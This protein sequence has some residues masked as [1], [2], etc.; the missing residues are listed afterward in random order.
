[1]ALFRIVDVALA[2]LL[3]KSTWFMK[4]TEE[5]KELAR[6]IKPN[7]PFIKCVYVQNRS[8]WRMCGLYHFRS[9]ITLSFKPCIL[10]YS[11]GVATYT[12]LVCVVFSF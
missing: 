6:K 10:K 9:N 7:Y 2:F 12:K 5:K 11:I 3:L 8:T 4:T 1:M